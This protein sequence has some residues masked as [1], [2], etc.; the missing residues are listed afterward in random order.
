[1]RVLVLHN[2][3]Q[4]AGGEDV[5]FAA[6]RDLLRRHGHEVLEYVEDNRDVGGMD[7][8]GLAARTVWSRASTRRLRELLR[9]TRPDVAHF[10][11]TFV[12]ISPSAYYACAEAGVPV[13]QT[14]HNYRLLCPGATFFRSGRVC[15]E[16]LGWS[17]PLPGVVHGCYR[18]SRAQTAVVAAMVAAHRRL[19]T[20]DRRV[21][22]YVALSE[23]AR[24]KFVEGGLPQ[25]KIQVKPNFAFPDCGTGQHEG[26]YA[27]FVGRASGEKGI[28][29][30]LEAWRR[31]GPAAR[32]KVVGSGPLETLAA[33]SPGNVEW[34]GQQPKARV[35]SLMKDAS[36]LVLPSTWYEAFP[37]VL[38]EAFA[39][40]LP[41]VASRLGAL[42]EL[43]E[44][45]RTGL[46]FAPGDAADL[47]AKIEWAL[48]RP[49]RLREMGR[50]ARQEFEAKYTADR[51][52]ERL[53]DIYRLAADGGVKRQETINGARRS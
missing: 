18:G 16:C 37:M 45:G 44:D 40:G 53:V 4:Q 43:V 27:L 11:N 20:W 19:G 13:V 35:L 3:Y 5:A 36:L 47:A 14:L 1:M 48:A 31:L 2:F 25:E 23:F 26:R 8:L 6:E 24:R 46:H 49:E 22:V 50:R 38:V 32:L 34:L 10:H 21:D 30:L 33:D 29:T 15:E 12:L 41:V 52:Y 51:N 42:A 17:V 7:P 9:R 28:E 39:T